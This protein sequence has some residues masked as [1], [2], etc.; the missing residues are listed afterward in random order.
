MFKTPNV[1]DFTFQKIFYHVQLCGENIVMVQADCFL[2]RQSQRHCTI[3]QP[4]SGTVRFQV[5]C[6]KMTLADV[7]QAI[8]GYVHILF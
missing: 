7:E 1:Y 5:G 6:L 8:C 2:V 3:T 4:L